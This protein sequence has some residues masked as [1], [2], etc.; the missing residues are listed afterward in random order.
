MTDIYATVAVPADQVDTARNIGGDQW[1]FSRAL[2][3]DSS[4]APPA[5]HYGS[6]GEADAALLA[7]IVNLPG[8]QV[9]YD[10]NVSATDAIAAMGLHFVV[11]EV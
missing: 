7:L 1:A 5:T 2:T 8:V 4:G 10:E 9:N 11:E 3:T 6:S